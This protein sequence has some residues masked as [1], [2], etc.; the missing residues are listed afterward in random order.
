[1]S[2][3]QYIR[4]RQIELSQSIA[5]RKK[6]YLDTRFWI[7]LRDAS[8]GVRTDPPACK[9]LHHL[10]RGVANGRLICPISATIYIELLKQPPSQ[11]RRLG[12]A[13]LME[14]LSRG[15]SMVPSQI[16]FGTEIYSFMAKLMGDEDLYSLQDLVWTKVAYVLGDSYPSIGRLSISDELIIQ[17]RVIDRLWDLSLSD[18]INLVDGEPDSPGDSFMKIAQEINTNNNINKDELR[19]YPQAYD[20]ELRGMIDLLKEVTG[21]SVI[22]IMEK[23]AGRRFIPTPNQRATTENN[24]SNVLYFA[25]RKRGAANELRSLHIGASIHAA[26]RWDKSR[27]FKPNDFHDIDHA[28]N[29]LGYCDVFLTEHSLHHLVTLPMLKLQDLNDCQ[30]FSDIEAAADCIRALASQS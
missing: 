14:D 10:R 19:S 5:P 12:A 28:T 7:I 13:Q 20:I 11:G 30:V 18:M 8:L 22:R 9:L 25:I 27:K 23:R 24:F 1:M 26:M 4:S 17:R 2:I 21:S 29:A 3:E 6:I 16:I 15:V